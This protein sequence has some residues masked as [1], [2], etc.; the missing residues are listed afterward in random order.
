MAKRYEK[1][2]L[3]ADYHED[4]K[5]VVETAVTM[6]ELYGAQ[7]HVIHVDEPI[8]AYPSDGAVW[9][10]QVYDLQAAIR[11]ESKTRM[12]L[13]QAEL[14]LPDEQCHLLEG[15]PAKQIHELCEQLNVDL[16]VLGTHGQHGFQLLLGSTASSVLHGSPCD[17][18]A[19][20]VNQSAS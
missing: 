1:I 8:S 5:D 19:V 16:I 17:V 7:L 20:R 11:K 18:L 13:L 15:Q 6:S 14:N 2:L 9:V 10:S 3:A 4:N 12:G